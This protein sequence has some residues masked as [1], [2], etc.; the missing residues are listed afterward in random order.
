M[1]RNYTVEQR[2]IIVVGIK[3]GKTLSE[4]NQLLYDL[5]YKRGVERSRIKQM[6]LSSYRM[7]KNTY[8]PKLSDEDLWRYI[9]SPQTL[10]E[11]SNDSKS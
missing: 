3:A 8:I 9:Q 10:G 7:M 5:Q 4:I 6:P 1:A 11:L 2:A